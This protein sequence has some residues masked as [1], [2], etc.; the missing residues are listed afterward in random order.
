[1]SELQYNFITTMSEEGL[2]ANEDP[3]LFVSDIEEEKSYRLAKAIC[4]NCPIKVPCFDYAM[5]VSP[6]G[7]WGGTTEY[8]R[9]RMKGKKHFMGLS[10]YSDRALSI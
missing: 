1:V 9:T 10:V 6:Y 3:G 8:E 7:V 5:E 2:C 4:Q